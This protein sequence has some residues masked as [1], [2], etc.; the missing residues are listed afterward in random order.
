[1]SL[2]DEREGEREREREGRKEEARKEKLNAH[3]TFDFHN[4]T[5]H[6]QRNLH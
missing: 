5:R 3:S 1:M 6:K 4:P 2:L